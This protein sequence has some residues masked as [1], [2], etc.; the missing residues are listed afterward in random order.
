MRHHGVIVLAALGVAACALPAAASGAGRVNVGA[1]LWRHDTN[2]I[3]ERATDYD[4]SDDTAGERA[5][6]WDVIGSGVGARV[7]YE[8]P[9]LLTVYGEAGTSQATVRDKDVADPMQPFASRGLNGGAYLAIGASVGDYFS[10]T[11]NLFWKVGGTMS[12]VSAG[13]D[14]DVNRSWDYDETRIAAE[15]RVGT[16]VQQIGF[17][18]GLR[19]VHS[20]ADLRETDR[21]NPPGQQSR[22]TE[23]SRDG[24]VDVLLGAQTRGPD[25]A[26]FT[27]LGMVGTF[28]AT[29]GLTIRF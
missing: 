2:L 23:L 26:G 8:F 5:K 15:A 19:M 22:L 9:R 12:S 4:G 13:L 25:V 24:A 27:E 16:W 6:D 21:T 14:R 3:V 11:G 7:S 1:I 18:G 28:S 10:S 17:Y 29:A 20:S